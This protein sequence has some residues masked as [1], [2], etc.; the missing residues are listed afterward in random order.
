V[1]IIVDAHAQLAH[2][3]LGIKCA[4]AGLKEIRRR[5]GFL[6]HLVKPPCFKAT[7]SNLMSLP[8]VLLT[9]PVKWTSVK[10][11]K[12]S[13]ITFANIWLGPQGLASGVI[14]GAFSPVMVAL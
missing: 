13:F 10:Q 7:P 11:S 14:I 1:N 12:E 2:C 4:R 9:F 8:P 5:G 6:L 3:D